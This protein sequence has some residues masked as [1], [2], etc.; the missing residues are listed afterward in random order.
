MTNSKVALNLEKENAA[1][2]LQKV[3]DDAESL[4]RKLGL[5]PYPVKYWI[6]DYDEVNQL[7]AYGGFQER[8]PHWRWGMQYDQQKKKARYTPSRIYELVINDDPAHAY[9][10][11][12]NEMADQK[13][14]I[15][16]VEGH[17]DFFKNNRWFRMFTEDVSAAAIMA[18]NAR[19][20]ESYMED[21]DIDVD[22]VERW[23]DNVLCIED[24]IDQYHDIGRETSVETEPETEVAE[25]EEKLEE[26][27]ISDDVKGEIFSDEWIESQRPESDFAMEP[28]KDLLLF[29]A[30]YGKAYDRSEGKAVEM[31]DWQRDV[32]RIL[33]K[34]SYYFAP[35]KMT[36]VMNEGWSAFWESVM[37]GDEAFA[38]D[39]EILTYAEHQAKVLG[40]QGMNP[41]KLGKE[42]WEYIENDANRRE[43][44]DKL[45]RIEGVNPSNFYDEIEFDEVLDHLEPP[46]P[47]GSLSGENYEDLAE[48]E[49]SEEFVDSESLDRA[50]SGELDE[51]EIDRYPW[52]LLSREGLARRNYSLL[53][54][55]NRGF[56]ERTNFSDIEEIGRYV[57]DDA[58][59]GSVEEALRDVDFLEGWNRM[60]AVRA[61]HNDVTFIDEFLSQE[62]VDEYSYFAYE[63]SEA[64]G[65]YHASGTD[66]E[67]VK[68]K[69]LLQFTNFGKPTIKVYDHNYQN[70]GELLLGHEY[71]GVMLNLKK[72]KRTMERIHEM[73]GK[74]VNLKTIVKKVDDNV[75]KMAKRQGE[76]PVPK[77]E[78]I[79]IR[80]DGEEFDRRELDW[81]EVEELAASEV[82][83]D[84]KPEGWLS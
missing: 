30:N 78:G 26:M 31:E 80:Y 47:L 76:E 57:F 53:K 65:Q 72:A 20:I 67:S 49:K 62:F 48:M 25:I 40:S 32:I 55:Q 44:I 12:S 61:T 84:T 11:V 10:Q 83:Y 5:N 68:K 15:T 4:A 69:L 59:Y 77:E 29:L 28:E 66:A 22:E 38:D 1:T 8:Y 81:D 82:D 41:Y 42:L 9:L 75:M 46:Y 39:D 52:K 71:N 13:A 34:E 16:H 73:W 58:V 17:A 79:L 63:Y 70:A 54:R 51:T 56:L 74:P 6:V 3:A 43:I 36:K 21:P 64:T 60:L 50:L 23:I 19:Q 18:R 27:D 24:N 2:G 14:V 35:Q 7:A 45:L 37:M 33:R